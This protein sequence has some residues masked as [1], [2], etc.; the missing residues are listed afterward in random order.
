MTL[1]S[2]VVTKHV[3]AIPRRLAED[4]VMVVVGA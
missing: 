2:A 4:A 1:N 3:K